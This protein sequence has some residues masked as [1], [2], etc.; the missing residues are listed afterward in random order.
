MT[1]VIKDYP[2]I[3]EKKVNGF[4]LA[5]GGF[6]ETWDL[7]DGQHFVAAVVYMN[8]RRLNVGYWLDD[9]SIAILDSSDLS[10]EQRAMLEGFIEESALLVVSEPSQSNKLN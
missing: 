8:D 1:A 2:N 3:F 6:L 7:Q 5:I 9:R 10:K 4:E